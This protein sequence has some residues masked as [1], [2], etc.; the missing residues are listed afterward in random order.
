M[1]LLV[2]VKTKAEEMDRYVEASNLLFPRQLPVNVLVK[3]PKEIK[4]ASRKK[5]VK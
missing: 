2:I 5:G 3:T 4:E 1:D